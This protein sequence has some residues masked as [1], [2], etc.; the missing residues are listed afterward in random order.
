VKVSPM[1]ITPKESGRIRE[2]ER[3]VEAEDRW[4]EDVWEWGVLLWE[5]GASSGA[6]RRIT[7]RVGVAEGIFGLYACCCVCCC[8]EMRG[9]GD[10]LVV[11]VDDIVVLFVVIL[12]LYCCYLE[13]FTYYSLFSWCLIRNVY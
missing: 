6:W 2:E 4:Q 7:L 13:L 12:L 11:V 3:V 5:R 10:L 9:G 8:W 1:W